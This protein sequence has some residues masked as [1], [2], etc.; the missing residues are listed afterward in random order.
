MQR[1]PQIRPQI[2]GGAHATIPLCASMSHKARPNM[3]ELRFRDAITFRSRSFHNTNRAAREPGAPAV[4]GNA[5][6]RQI[7]MMRSKLPRRSWRS[8][9]GADR[10]WDSP[11]GLGAFSNIPQF[12]GSRAGLIRHR[13]NC[14][15]P[16]RN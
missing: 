14:V 16:K 10:L 13:S 3:E 6:C 11:G 5:T 7:I 8:L 4:Q 12:R 9:V 1:Q 2:Q 15:L